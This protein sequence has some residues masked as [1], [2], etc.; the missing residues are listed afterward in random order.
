MSR[1]TETSMRTFSKKLLGMLWV[2]LAA[3]ALMPSAGH[4]G[5]FSVSPVRIFMAAKDRTTAVTVT[6][7][8]DVELV[9]QADVFLW[10][11]T[12]TGQE[13]LTPTEDLIIAPPIIKLAPR[14]KQ[15]IRLAMLKPVPTDQQLTYRIIV[16]EIPEA[17]P[18][19]PGVQLQIA[20]AFSMPIFISPPSVKRQLVCEPERIVAADTVR[21][22][23]EN[24]GNAYAFASEFKLSNASGEAIATSN[25]GGYVLAGIKRSFELKRSGTLIPAG[26][27]QLVVTQDDLSVQTF[28]SV[29]AN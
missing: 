24:R 15:V 6:N 17:K 19:E 5:Q 13:D 4:A 11:Q 10:K 28:D 27:V 8:S 9:M 26:K 1:S 3:L 21:V 20:L 23:C 22:T 14:A 7:E 2:G 25:A 16:R 29:L 18:V 12:T